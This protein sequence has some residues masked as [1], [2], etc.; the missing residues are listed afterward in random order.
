MSEKRI[1]L[2]LSERTVADLARAG[3]LKLSKQRV[4]LLAAL[5]RE[6]LRDLKEMDE[7]DLGEE[8]LQLVLRLRREKNES[9]KRAS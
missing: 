3:N 6:F 8:P 4:K 1:S 2:T 7:L 9:Q 5:F